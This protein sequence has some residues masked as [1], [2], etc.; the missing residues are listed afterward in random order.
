MEPSEVQRRIQQGLSGVDVQVSGDGSHF[1]AL[2]VGAVFAGQSAVNRQRL[3]YAALGDSIASGAVHAITIK[4]YT[5]EEWE[6]AR[7]LKIS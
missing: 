4:A 7:K 6:K 1:E 3:V 5:P 2:V